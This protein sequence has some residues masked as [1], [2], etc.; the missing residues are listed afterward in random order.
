MDLNAM[1]YVSENV[2]DLQM[3]SY[4]SLASCQRFHVIPIHIIG[5]ELNYK[6]SLNDLNQ[7]KQLEFT[8]KFSNHLDSFKERALN[9]LLVIRA[10]GFRPFSPKI[11]NEQNVCQKVNKINWLSNIGAMFIIGVESFREKRLDFAVDSHSKAIFLLSKSPFFSLL[12][13]TSLTESFQAQ[14]YPSI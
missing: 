10:A 12:H 3:L 7:R 13:Y 14:I 2:A 8:Q 4:I 1:D 11:H 5:L 9:E 6:P